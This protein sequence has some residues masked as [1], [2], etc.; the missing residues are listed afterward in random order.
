[1]AETSRV[2]DENKRQSLLGPLEYLARSG[3]HKPSIYSNL[4]DYRTRV[5]GDD[6]RFLKRISPI[7]SEINP[8]SVIFFA[9]FP[10]NT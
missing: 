3:I 1:M 9:K 5:F 7:K 4:V 6:K 10:S 8:L 2:H